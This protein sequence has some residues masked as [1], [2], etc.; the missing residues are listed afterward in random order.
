MLRPAVRSFGRV[1][2]A[3]LFVPTGIPS[4][5]DDLVLDRIHQYGSNSPPDLEIMALLS[6][7]ACQLHVDISMFVIE[8]NGD[9]AQML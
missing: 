7:L 2:V 1:R 4:S 3:V 9:V 6:D 8:L 5:G